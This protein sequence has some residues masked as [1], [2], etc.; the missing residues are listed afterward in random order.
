VS[1][2]PVMM[3]SPDKVLQVNVKGSPSPSLAPTLSCAVSSAKRGFGVAVGPVSI[4]GIVF[5]GPSSSMIMIS[6]AD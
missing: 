3:A 6:A 4:W 2:V 1:P 5:V